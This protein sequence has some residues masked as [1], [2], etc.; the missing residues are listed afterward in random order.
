MLE[1]LLP[2][3]GVV[4][5]HGIILNFIDASKYFN[6][7]FQKVEWQNDEAFIFGKHYITKRKVAWYG[8]Y[9]FEYTYSKST[10]KALFWTNELLQLKKIVEDITHESYNSCLCNLYHD[11]DEGMA[12]HSDDEKKILKNSSIASLTFG[13]TRKF[14][15]KHKKD[16]TLIMLQLTAG[17][18]LEMKGETQIY[19][20]HR[21]PK[22]KQK[23]GPRINLTFRKIEL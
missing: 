21:L 15:F 13:A 10:K 14:G 16:K 23:V 7:L 17:Q 3:D 8:D 6:D 2:F 19:W 12:W 9:P 18:L 4:Y 5:D 20:W 11:G 1:N 22:T